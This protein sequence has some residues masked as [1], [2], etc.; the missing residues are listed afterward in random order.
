MDNDSKVYTYSLSTGLWPFKSK[1]ERPMFLCSYILY[2]CIGVSL[3]QKDRFEALST[4]VQ[5]LIQ[6][7]YH[8]CEG[9][10]KR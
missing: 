3:M 1:Q 9:V 5:E 6:E 8:N 4:M 7:N 10:Q 2:V